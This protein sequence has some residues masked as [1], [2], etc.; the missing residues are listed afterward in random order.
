MT[1]KK[2]QKNLKGG[3]NDNPNSRPPSSLSR[4][5]SLILEKAK[6]PD[7][8]KVFTLENINQMD[9]TK[10]AKLAGVLMTIFSGMI[11]L[12]KRKGKQISEKELEMEK[13]IK[14]QKKLMKKENLESPE[15]KLKSPKSPYSKGLNT[16]ILKLGSIILLGSL[17][18]RKMKRSLK[19]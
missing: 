16:K 2:T 9:S 4:V 12:K 18:Y 1:A 8:R 5:R 15:K 17:A 10:K 7:I 11:L 3:S 14:Q 6:I 19:K 13:L